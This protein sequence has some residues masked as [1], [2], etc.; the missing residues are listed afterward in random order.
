[1]SF[2]KSLVTRHIHAAAASRPTGQE[3][4][5]VFFYGTPPD[6]AQIAALAIGADT[7]VAEDEGKTRIHVRWP[8]VSLHITIDPSWDKA[9]QMQGMR[10]WT[11]RFPAKVRALEDVRR[12]I[13]SFDTVAACYGSVSKPG[14]DADNKAVALL[15]ALIADGGGF[16]FSRNSFYGPDRLRITGFDEDPVWLGTPPDT[17]A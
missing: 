11:G 1:M 5:A 12:L 6:A 2:L 15:Q 13:E 8:D 14:L 7:E 16:F 3:A 4:I 9:T 10:A 17:P